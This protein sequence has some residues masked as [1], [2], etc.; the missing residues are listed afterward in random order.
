MGYQETS[1]WEHVEGGDSIS[2]VNWELLGFKSHN[3]PKAGSA[4]NRER[5]GLT[6][7]S[8]SQSRQHM[9]LSYGNKW[10]GKTDFKEPFRWA[11]RSIWQALESRELALN[12]WV[13][14]DLF[15]H[16]RKE[17]ERGY[18]RPVGSKEMEE[19]SGTSS[20]KWA[21]DLSLSSHESLLLWF[22]LMANHWY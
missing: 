1:D 14:N 8:V 7:F 16:E 13:W 5:A 22:W 15:V 6:P 21:F 20:R 4:V 17:A 10:A 19:T 18:W 11:R 2:S 9:A 12:S 3:C